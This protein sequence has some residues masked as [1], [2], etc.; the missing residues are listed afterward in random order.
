MSGGLEGFLAGALGQAGQQAQNR[1][2]LAAEELKQTNLLRLQEQS[3]L[4]ILDKRGEQDRDLLGIRGEQDRDLLG[5]RGE[6]DMS[7]RQFE[8]AERARQQSIADQRADARLGRSEAGAQSRLAAQLAHERERD[9]RSGSVLTSDAEGN[10]VRYN[11][12]TNEIEPVRRSAYHDLSAAAARTGQAGPTNEAA[13][14]RAEPVRL[15][16]AGGGSSREGMSTKGKEVLDLMAL[17]QDRDKSI[18]TV[19]GKDAKIQTIADG[20]G[21]FVTFVDGEPALRVD[22]RGVAAPIEAD[23]TAGGQGGQRSQDGALSRAKKALGDWLLGSSQTQEE[24]QASVT[25]RQSESGSLGSAMAQ[26]LEA[27]R[28][29]AQSPGARIRAQDPETGEVHR[30]ESR[31]GKWVQVD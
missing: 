30:F 12:V 13:A 25:P 15:A 21:N 14:I 20:F 16:G 7:A 17:G 11:L 19:F 2:D 5:I 27:S 6:Q 28:P 4:R 22:D 18:D 24:V 3:Q 1:I 31:G 8:A 10:A 9:S 29:A 26:E 23:G